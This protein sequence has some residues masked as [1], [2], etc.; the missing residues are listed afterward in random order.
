MRSV[1]KLVYYCDHC[2]K[3]GLSRAAM[4][5]HERACTMNPDRVCR[6]SIDEAEGHAEFDLRDVAEELFRRAPLDQDDLAWLRSTVTTADEGC[7]ACM[8]AALRQ[9]EVEY[10]VDPQGC[11]LFDYDAEVARFRDAEREHWQQVEYR[12]L[13]ATMY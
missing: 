1:R 10:H 8:L 9:S 5:R 12:D 6:W 4:E 7:P 3:H 13:Q 2:R 11:R